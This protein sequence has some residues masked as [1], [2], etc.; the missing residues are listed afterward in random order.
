MRNLIRFWS[1]RLGSGCSLF[2]A[3]LIAVA[4]IAAAAFWL[5]A[6]AVRHWL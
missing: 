4:A 3:L 6:Y 2:L 1:W 5:G